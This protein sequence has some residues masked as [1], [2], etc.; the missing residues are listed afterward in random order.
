MAAIDR[1]GLDRHRTRGADGS[2]PS[3]VV[4]GNGKSVGVGRQ[5]QITG[6]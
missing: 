5:R 1:R 4:H 2:Q 3:R 6:E